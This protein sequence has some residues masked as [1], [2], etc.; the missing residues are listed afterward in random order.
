MNDIAIKI[1][2]VSKEYRLGMIGGATLRGEIQSK[3]ARLRGK[4]DPNLKIGE[5]SH[6]KNERFLALD[7]VSLEIKKGE[8]V[9]IIGHNGAGKSTLLKLICRVTAPTKGEI[10]MNGRITSM[11]EVGTGFHGELTGRE[12]VFLNGAILGLSKAEIQN[13][14]DEIVEFSEVGQFIDTP[15]KRYSSG[16]HVKLGFAVAAHLDSEIM[17]MDEVL[18]VG[19]VA[20]QKKCIERMRLAAEDEGRTI[21]YVSHN[22]L[23]IRQ[24][25][26]RVIVLSQGKI[27]FDGDPEKAI[28]LYMPKGGDELYK[29]YWDFSEVQKRRAVDD[30]N[31][32]IASFR[33]AE[34]NG[35]EVKR[36]T[37]LHFFVQIHAKENCDR[38]FLRLL[39]WNKDDSLIGMTDTKEHRLN[40]TVGE[41]LF[42]GTCNTAYLAPGKN[43]LDIELCGIDPSGEEFFYESVCRMV[44][45]KIVDTDELPNN[46]WHR[47]WWGACDFG[48]INLRKLNI[49]HQ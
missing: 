42:E 41:N 9:G 45:F 38:L 18:A 13:K 40:L 27:I 47:S 2:H 33:F 15:V 6:E 35:Y 28:E 43:K 24:L 12:N 22:M 8:R 14:F 3:F 36:G 23:T 7:D 5:K 21:L 39:Y 25:C 37:N 44:Y 4:E 26:S 32:S 11:L 46:R 31:F 19:D 16:M 29:E 20:F 48:E 1:S 34:K 49:S 17:I 10:C 30:D